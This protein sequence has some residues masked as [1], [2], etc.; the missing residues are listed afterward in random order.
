MLRRL[1]QLS[2]SLALTALLASCDSSNVEQQAAVTNTNIRELRVVTSGGFTAAYN[3]LAPQFERETG[4]T[5][6]T[7]YGASA[8]GA[9]NSIPERLGRGERFD[10]II[11]SRS[12]LDN[13]T[14]EGFV[15]PDT[16]R[17]LVLSTIG[18]AVKE[19]AKQPDISTP[20]AFVQALR[21]AKSFGYSASA[22]GTYLSTV[23]L[24]RLGL[25]T[26]LEP[27]STRV[28]GDRV[29]AVIA[30]GEVEIG[31]QQISEILPIEGASFVGPIPQEYQKVTTFS[32]GIT[33]NSTSPLD[34]LVLID[35]LSSEGVANT[36]A[37]TGLEPVVSLN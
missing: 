9:P 6:K 11:L 36:I 37:A 20:A 18:M 21:S 14:I 15:V 12:S 24:P 8:G 23:L 4:I 25:W 31:F 16:R 22:S 2:A 26:E 29:A 1:Y 32:T 27:K 28:V 3:I 34:A 7:E 17:D 5:L 13:L 35:Y 19:G 33:T 30:R 10:L